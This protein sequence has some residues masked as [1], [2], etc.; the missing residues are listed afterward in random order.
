MIT[1]DDLASPEEAAHI[2]TELR[3]IIITRPMAAAGAT[4]VIAA[5]QQIGQNPDNLEWGGAIALR[6]AEQIA[7]AVYQAMAEIAPSRPRVSKAVALRRRLRSLLGIG[8]R[9]GRNNVQQK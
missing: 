7:A 4:A 9:S 8:R 1:L 2:R 3:E 6:G 5:L